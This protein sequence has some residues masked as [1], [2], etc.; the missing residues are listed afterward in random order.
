M[1]F[2]DQGL[3]LNDF[4]VSVKLDGKSV[5]GILDQE[6]IEVD[7]TGSTKPTFLYKLSDRPDVAHNSTLILEDGTSYLVKGPPEPDGTGMNKLI[8]EL[9]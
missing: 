1:F 8:L 3:F 7:F 2:E 6:Y 5:S 4:A 9:Q